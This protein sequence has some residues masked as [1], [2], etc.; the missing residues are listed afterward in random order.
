M[1]TPTTIDTDTE[2]SAVNSILGAIGQSPVTTLGTVDE[3]TGE[4][5]HLGVLNQTAFSLSGLSWALLKE[6]KVT[7]DGVPETNFTV[8]GSTLTFTT[9]PPANAVIRIYTEKEIYNTLANPEI[10]FIYSILTEVNKDVQHEGWMFNIERHKEIQ[11]SD[12]NAEGKGIIEIPANILS[13][14]LHDGL[15]NKTQDLVRRK[16]NGKYVL[17]DTVNHTERFSDNLYLDVVYLWPYEDLPGVFKRYIT[18]RS[19]VR[20]ATQLVSNPQLVQLLQQQEGFAR[21][22]CIEYECNQGDHSF[23]GHPHDSYYKSFQPYTA[24][25]R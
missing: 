23:F 10:S 4:L 15:T 9:A 11:L 22:S 7:I 13:Y 5:S 24:L 3:V 12:I 14:D 16:I 8:S 1:A 2:L 18:Y 19:A 20:A 17:Y 25:R 21:A 6:V